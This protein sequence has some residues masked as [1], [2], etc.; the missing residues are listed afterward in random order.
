MVNLCESETSAFTSA[1]AFFFTAGA[2]CVDRGL[3]YH[4]VPGTNSAPR[5]M[6]LWNTNHFRHKN[7]T[8]LCQQFANWKMAIEIVSFPINSMVMFYSYVT[9]YQRVTSGKLTIT[10][11]QPF[12]QVK[13]LKMSPQ[14]PGFAYTKNNTSN[15][16]DIL[17]TRWIKTLAI[18]AVILT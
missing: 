3:L 17:I 1:T 14:N 4:L 12:N 11:H 9:V 18:L 13:C 10:K 5:K 16:F 15:N 2:Q 6:G 8:W 7:P